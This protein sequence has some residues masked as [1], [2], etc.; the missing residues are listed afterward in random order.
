MIT[1]EREIQDLRE[2]IIRWLEDTSEP[3]LTAI[4]LLSRA[5]RLLERV[6]EKEDDNSTTP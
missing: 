6:I 3:P 4:S 2:K 5:E 1:L